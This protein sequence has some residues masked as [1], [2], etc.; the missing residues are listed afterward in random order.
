MDDRMRLLLSKAA[1]AYSD[2]SDPFAT[3]WLAENNVTLDEC[4]AMSEFISMSIKAVLKV[5]R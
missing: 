4:V 5:K 2:G 1:D 3:H